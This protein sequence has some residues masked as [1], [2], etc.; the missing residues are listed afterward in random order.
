MT[1]GQ[2]RV[3][4]LLLVLL[5]LE[6]LR[7]PALKSWFHTAWKNLGLGLAGNENIIPIKTVPGV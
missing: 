4:V 2:T 3:L 1:D 7:M 5:G 6:I